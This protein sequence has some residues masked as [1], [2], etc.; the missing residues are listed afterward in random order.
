MRQLLDLLSSFVC[1]RARRANRRT[2]D[3]RPPGRWQPMLEMLEDRLVP[4]IVVPPTGTISSIRSN[5]NGTAIPA[6]RT[7]WFSSVF[8]VSG[9]GADPVTLH[10]T[11]QTIAFSAAGTDY[12]LSVPDAAITFSP[13]VTTATTTFDTSTNTWVS[14]LPK[15]FSGNAF[16]AGLAFP[17]DVALP[18]GINPVTWQGSF[19]TDTAGVSLNWQWAAA[20]Y[21]NFSTDYNAVGVKPLDSNSLTVYHNSDHAGTPENFKTLVTGGAR[22]GGGSNFTGSYSATGKVTPELEVPVPPQTAKLSGFVYTY[23][24]NGTPVATSGVTVT[25]YDANGNIVTTATTNGDGFYEFTGLTPGTYSLGDDRVG[26]VAVVGTGN[27]SN[28]GELDEFGSQI[29]HIE[30]SAGETGTNYDFFGD[31][32]ET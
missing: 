7:I 30:L 8:K 18:G 24:S 13:T 3:Q 1:G 23:D 17:V 4:T 20:V 12:T 32:G 25:L 19:S 26:D 22:G 29:I 9:L 5:F 6:G 16:M 11:S 27:G 28:D 2:G 15:N 10:V 21:K 31:N 14:V